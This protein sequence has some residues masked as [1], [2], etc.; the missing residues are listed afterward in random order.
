M[1][2]KNDG[3]NPLDMSSILDEVEKSRTDAP[4]D[5]YI[6]DPFI[7]GLSPRFPGFIV[8]VDRTQT[9]PKILRLKPIRT[10]RD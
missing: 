2:S 9:P 7:C 8:T 1:T 10:N 6:K 4:L 5:D 3:S